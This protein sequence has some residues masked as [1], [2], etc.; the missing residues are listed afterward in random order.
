MARRRLWY[1]VS[2]LLIVYGA[3]LPNALMVPVSA[4]R[5]GWDL[6]ESRH[7]N[8]YSEIQGGDW[9]SLMD[10][11]EDEWEPVASVDI[12]RVFN[13]D[14]ADV[15]LVSMCKPKVDVLGAT[16]PSTHASYPKRM[17]LNTCV[18][19]HTCPTA[20]ACAVENANGTL[21]SRKLY[22]T[23]PTRR[24]RTFVHEFGHALGLNH[25]D[26]LLHWDSVMSTILSPGSK[27]TGPIKLGNANKTTFL[28]QPHD[29]RDIQN[30]W[31]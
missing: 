9:A 28:L 15:I 17:R 5:L 4:H 2:A 16:Y 1:V 29:I 22:S 8:Y 31:P 12:R 21:S 6:V 13:I 11:A 14:G 7:L 30:L 27:Q 19:A 26:N 23:P 3:I 24:T 10:L 20:R 18:L 25:A